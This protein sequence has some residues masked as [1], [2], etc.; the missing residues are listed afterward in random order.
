MLHAYGNSSSQPESTSGFSQEQLSS[1][2]GSFSLAAVNYGGVAATA[3]AAMAASV[4]TAVASSATMSEDQENEENKNRNSKLTSNEIK[5]R[6][7]LGPKSTSTF[8][9]KGKH[10]KL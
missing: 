2:A 3:A 7:G 10:N 1:A 6:A 5:D 8:I 9:K 4:V